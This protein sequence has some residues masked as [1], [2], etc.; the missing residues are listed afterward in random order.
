MLIRLINN[1]M[2]I[3]GPYD[4]KDTFFTNPNLTP[5]SVPVDN[6]K[7]KIPMSNSERSSFFQFKKVYANFGCSW[8]PYPTLK[9]TF[10]TLVVMMKT[11][12]DGPLVKFA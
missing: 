6:T 12:M 8:T 3:Y 7:I 9:S 5:Q 11:F 2:A 4:C 10:C 1:L